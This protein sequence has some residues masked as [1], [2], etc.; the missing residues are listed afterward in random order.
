MASLNEHAVITDACVTVL[1]V[2]VG[3]IS[4]AQFAQYLALLRGF[5]RFGAM[6]L[7]SVARGGAQRQTPFSNRAKGDW[8]D[9]AGP[10]VQLRWVDGRGSPT[11]VDAWA[12]LQPSKEVAGVVGVCRSASGPSLA[13]AHAELRGAA[14]PHRFASRG[15]CY[16]LYVFEPGG[17]GGSGEGAADQLPNVILIPA[18]TERMST[19]DYL[20]RLLEDFVS[21][22]VEKLD[23]W[24]LDLDGNMPVLQTRLDTRSVEESQLVARRRSGR[25]S[26]YMADCA[27]MS[28]SPLDAHELYIA[29]A[30]E[31]KQGRDKLWYA[32]AL[33]GLC[34]AELV[35]HQLQQ[36]PPGGPE[37]PAPRPV[38]KVRDQ[39][40]EALDIYSHWR[41]ATLEN[42][43]CLKLAQFLVDAY[44]R[45]GV[46]WI[47]LMDS[48]RWAV[49]FSEDLPPM[50]RLRVLEKIQ[51]LY[52][53][54]GCRRK[55]AFF[56]C[57]RAQLLC[58]E[59]KQTGAAAD[60]YVDLL[61]HYVSGDEKVAG[62][63]TAHRRCL[64][65]KAGE[66][67][68]PALE[69][70][71][72]NWL[73][74][75]AKQQ[76]DPMASSL[77]Q[78]RAL[79]APSLLSRGL[80]AEELEAEL[81]AVK[82]RLAVVEA[83]GS[84]LTR[85]RQDEIER[86]TAQVSSLQMCLQTA[87][88]QA[89][90]QASM[91]EAVQRGLGMFP[92]SRQSKA[93][94]PRLL[95]RVDALDL[96]VSE[97]PRSSQHNKTDHGPFL[98]SSFMARDAALV[99]KPILW[100]AGEVATVACQLVNPLS[101]LVEVVDATLVL[102]D[103]FFDASP[104][105]FTLQA[106]EIRTVW[107]TG[108]CSGIMI[109][110]A[111]PGGQYGS[112]SVVAAAAARAPAPA[113]PEL[114]P[115]P[116]PDDGGGKAASALHKVLGVS[117]T[118]FGAVHDYPI[119]DDGQYAHCDS[120]AEVPGPASEPASADGPPPPSDGE[121]GGLV[122]TV[123]P[124]MP[125]LVGRLLGCGRGEVSLEAG[126]EKEIQ[127]VLANTGNGRC[128]AEG[129]TL[130]LRALRRDGGPLYKA[131]TKK[132]MAAE[133]NVDT[134]A[135]L[136]WSDEALQTAAPLAAGQTATIPLRLLGVPGCASVALT[137]AYDG[138]GKSGYD[139]QLSLDGVRLRLTGD[140]TDAHPAVPAP[141][142]GLP[143]PH[144]TPA[145]TVV[146]LTSDYATAARTVAEGWTVRC[147]LVAVQPPQPD[148]AAA[149]EAVPLPPAVQDEKG[150][151]WQWKASTFSFYELRVC[152]TV[153]AGTGA[154]AVRLDSPLQGCS[155]NGALGYEIPGSESAATT[156]T[157]YTHTIGLFYAEP[158]RTEV[159]ISID[160][161]ERSTSNQA[162]LVVT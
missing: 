68:W 117:M 96:P 12:D 113:E 159:E 27:L 156:A 1:A 56:M 80:P 53:D 10:Q 50:L 76:A 77:W 139:R 123:V 120:F 72:Y 5:D 162:C 109:S 130:S 47:W 28:G 157:E 43:C 48:V 59:L 55:T 89:V 25:M 79:S 112:S 52:S 122:V 101:V 131:K 7:Q 38:G 118:V 111:W 154:L 32:S 6:G 39:M 148:P 51:R 121:S 14:A 18:P 108:V 82:S 143:L 4:D 142:S 24:V 114:E 149:T 21:E 158:T 92:P 140:T 58:D 54:L 107:L 93:M 90:E 70:C 134:P 91:A 105:T 63:N 94:R 74:D 132:Q 145:A 135:P 3:D 67:N 137:L 155:Y 115:E 133:G 128:T 31:C 9:A 46:R 61:D 40:I 75:I 62:I 45:E 99:K 86:L 17:S 161:A 129:L 11:A 42:E 49:D 136:S 35:Q 19:G 30:E 16:R 151:R 37:P 84:S 85:G 144:G 87:R 124:A 41:L 71:V 125:K 69:I 83:E 66:C 88:V 73:S 153:A 103:P 160:S 78:L 13:S 146:D 2:P 102:S 95:R 97:R 33:E 104:Q 57:L 20:N 36:T 147:E 110:S 15:E 126:E 8:A 29:A 23:E 64:T 119:G 150:R 127:L 22:L 100:V 65:H 44:R 26:K 116:E 138:G 98:Y 141:G 81:L 34:A 152:V 60:L 106:G